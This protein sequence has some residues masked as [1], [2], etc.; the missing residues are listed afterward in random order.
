MADIDI[1]MTKRNSTNT[2][3]DNVNPITKATLV[4]SS[5]GNTVEENVSGLKNYT[6]L[7][8]GKDTEGIFVTYQR[9]RYDGTLLMKSVLSG[10]TTPLYTT[11]TE[12]WYAPNGT[13]IVS[14]KAYTITYDSDG[15]VVSEV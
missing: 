6:T 7:K 13:T 2:E 9:K 14:T 1:Q 12:T 11:R 3:W 10:G 15:S 5:D 8:S 4:T